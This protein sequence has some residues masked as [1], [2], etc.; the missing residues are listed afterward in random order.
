MTNREKLQE[1][2]PYIEVIGTVLIDKRTEQV[3]ATNLNYN[4]L[5]VEY[6]NYSGKEK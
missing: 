3:L 5:N 2:F 6:D 1:I 4:W